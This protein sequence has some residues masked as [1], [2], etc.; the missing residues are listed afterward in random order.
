M[1]LLNFLTNFLINKN[2]KNCL[3]NLNELIDKNL[4]K[5]IFIKSKNKHHLLYDITQKNTKSKYLI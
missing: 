4:I 3:H 2:L 1:K 5:L